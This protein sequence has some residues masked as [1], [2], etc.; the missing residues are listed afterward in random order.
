MKDQHV[1][2][3]AKTQNDGVKRMPHERDE[4]PEGQG[5]KQ[6]TIIEQAAKDIDS[7]MVDTDLHNQPGLQKPR[8]DAKAQPQAN[9]KQD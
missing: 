7:G 8:P 4:S 3:D 2:T 5:N 9:T 1:N 6:H